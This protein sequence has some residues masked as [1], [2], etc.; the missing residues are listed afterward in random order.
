VSGNGVSIN[1]SLKNELQP[2]ALREELTEK[3]IL[4]QNLEKQ[5]KEAS[6][7]SWRT[8]NDKL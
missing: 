8:M 3:D 2:E 6:L 4:L 7:L 5:V 1:T